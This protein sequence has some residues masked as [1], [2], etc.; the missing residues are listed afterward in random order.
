MRL[1]AILVALATIVFVDAT[2]A[3]QHTPTWKRANDHHYR[4]RRYVSFLFCCAFEFVHS[5]LSGR[6]RWCS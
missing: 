1:S 5:T 3:R 6:R 2:L 4:R